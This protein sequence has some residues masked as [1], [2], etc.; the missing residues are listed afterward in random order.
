MHYKVVKTATNLLV[1][2]SVA[3][4]DPV[5]SGLF[6]LDPDLEP[7]LLEFMYLYINFYTVKNKLI[8]YFEQK[9]LVLKS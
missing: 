6:W 8:E 3:D 9:N 2:C 1:Q 5:R 7:I 4:T